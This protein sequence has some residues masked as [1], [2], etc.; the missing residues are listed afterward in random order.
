[1]SNMGLVEKKVFGALLVLSDSNHIVRASKEKIARAMGYKRSGGAITFA[2]KNLEL[3]NHIV[4]IEEGKYK[5][6]L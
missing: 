5:V 6:F 1:M 3:T 4:K 2:L